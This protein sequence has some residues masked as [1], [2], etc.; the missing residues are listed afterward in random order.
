MKLKRFILTLISVFCVLSSSSKKKEYT[1]IHNTGC[2]YLKL[3]DVQRTD[4]ATF[5]S[6]LY[7][8]VPGE[9]L[10][11]SPHTYIEDEFC[12]KYLI[13]EIEG[14]SMG[15]NT[16][17][18]TGEIAFTMK[19]P[20]LP[21]KCKFMDLKVANEPFTTIAFWGIHSKSTRL[22]K[23]FEY[24]DTF[25]CKDK[26]ILYKGSCVIQGKFCDYD[27]V[28]CPKTIFLQ[29]LPLTDKTIDDYDTVRVD[30]DG[31]FTL[32]TIVDAPSWTYLRGS[33]LR[34]PVFLYPDDTLRVVIGKQD[35]LWT[36][37]YEST[38]G[39]DIMPK[40][41]S[42]DPKYVN[43]GRREKTGNRIVLKELESENDSIMR[44]ISLLCGYMSWKY[45]LSVRETHLLYLQF[46]SVIDDITISRIYANFFYLFYPSGLFSLSEEAFLN[47]ALSPD[48]IRSHSFMR[49]INTEDYSY[50]M[51]PSQLMIRNLR[52]LPTT[53]KVAHP[54]VKNN[55]KRIFESYTGRIMD[56]EWSNR[57]YFE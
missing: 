51:L 43:N 21:D 35:G 41:L 49:D 15:E 23:M 57:L 27:T 50:F 28:S 52:N 24:C 47:I 8:N 42:A 31:M 7:Q 22:P 45:G 4:T 38:K 17:P 18:L 36:T 2:N 11:L 10:H 55:R 25:V 33:K 30:Q 19:F 13:V 1:Y 37:D 3:V 56:E 34:I 46:K 48:A 26:D 44:E 53:S 54:T 14:A 40:L 20:P 9:K 32:K 39:N 6:F 16:A 12:N 29:Y 5:V